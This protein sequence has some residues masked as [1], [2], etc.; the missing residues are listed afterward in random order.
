MLETVIEHFD[1][2]LDYVDLG[3]IESKSMRQAFDD[4]NRLGRILDKLHDE[5]SASKT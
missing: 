4:L 2:Y 3:V 1:N 5:L